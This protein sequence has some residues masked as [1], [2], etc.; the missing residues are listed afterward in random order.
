MKILDHSW[1]PE[2]YLVCQGGWFLIFFLLTFQ[3]VHIYTLYS[4]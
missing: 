1:H 4:I 3:K 2:C